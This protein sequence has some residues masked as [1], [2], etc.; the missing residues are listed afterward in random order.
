MNNQNV[1]SVRLT[2]YVRELAPQLNEELSNLFL[3]KYGDELQR[4]I[5][6]SAREEVKRALIAAKIICAEHV[7]V[8][9]EPYC[10]RCGTKIK[11]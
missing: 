5:Q 11:E 8:N 2:T 6:H 10:A 1:V 3:V 4:H 9:G 7:R